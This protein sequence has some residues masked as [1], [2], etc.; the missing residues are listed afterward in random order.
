MVGEL[1][2]EPDVQPMEIDDDDIISYAE[3]FESYKLI[4][5]GFLQTDRKQ[6][7]SLFATPNQC[8]LPTQGKQGRS[9]LSMRIMA[10][11]SSVWLG[12]VI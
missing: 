12:L 10:Q 11:S 7:A 4:P 3:A 1:T 8:G 9:P 6:Q 2:D 5:P